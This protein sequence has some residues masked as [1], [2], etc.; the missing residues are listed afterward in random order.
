VGRARCR[1]PGTSG[2]S[3]GIPFSLV[4]TSDLLGQHV[5]RRVKVAGTVDNARS[6]RR[7]LV[8]LRTE[9]GVLG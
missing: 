9:A 3:A 8:P 6:E 7:D 1:R 2:A 4:G 5:G